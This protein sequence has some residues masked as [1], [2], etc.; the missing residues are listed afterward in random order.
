[1]S[2]LPL[3]RRDLAQ[4]LTDSCYPPEK[5]QQ[6]LEA[7]DNGQMKEL[8]SVLSAH[9]RALLNKIHER[10]GNLDCLDYLIYQLKQQSETADK[11]KS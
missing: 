4:T 1:M 8:N 9:R 3:N 5:I 2:Y 6:F 11:E 7:Y 10:Q